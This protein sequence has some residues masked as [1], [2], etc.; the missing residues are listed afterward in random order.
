MDRVTGA[1]K[2]YIPHQPVHIALF[3]LLAFLCYQAHQWV[4]HFTGAVLCGGFGS[5]TFTVAT[6]RQSCFPAA[7]ETLSGPLLTYGLAWTGLFLLRSPKYVLFA[8]AL[9]F[10]SFAHQRFIQTLTGRGDE[11]V[12]AQQW[13]ATA[14][15]PVVA[16]VVFLIGLPPVI[17]AFRAIANRRRLLVFLGSWLLPLPLLFVMLI[18]D[19]ILFGDRYRVPPGASFLGI[20]LIVLVTDLIALALLIVL[21]PRYLRPCKE[22]GNTD[23]KAD[24]L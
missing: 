17:A 9:I 2:V 13:F 15:R 23:A 1:L 24:C 7:L 20:S 8:Y 6:T 14:S 5:M 22:E 16:L 11:L 3:L 4:R 12:L 10:A 21:G 19:K 18:G